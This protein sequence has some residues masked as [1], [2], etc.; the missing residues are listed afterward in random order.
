M[1]WGLLFRIRQTLKGSLWILPLVGGLVGL[2]LY[3]GGLAFG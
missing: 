1:S 2:A 3:L